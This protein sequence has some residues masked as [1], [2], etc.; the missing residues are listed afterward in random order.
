MNLLQRWR[1]VR[2]GFSPAFWVANFTE[3]FERVGYYSTQAVLAIF[4]TEQL[5]FSAE[6]TG[7]LMGIATFVVYGLPILAGTLADR[8]GF[9]R[10]LMFAYLLLTAGYYMLGSVTA[11]WMAPVRH[12]MGDKWLVLL[13]LLLPAAGPGIVKPCVAGTTARTSTEEARSMGYS[14]YYTLV[15]IGGTIGPLLAWLVRE[16]LGLGMENVFR[17]ASLSVFAMFWVTLFLY[18]EPPS[19]PGTQVTTIYAAIKNMVFVVL[20]NFRFVVFLLITSGFYIVYWQMWVSAPVFLRRYV[21]ANANVDQML[22]IEGFTIIALQIVI[23]FLTRKIPAVQAIAIGFLI[24]GAS[25]TL[26]AV[27]PSVW[28]FPVMLVVLALGEITQASR[29]YEYCSLIAPPG[30]AGL[31]MGYAFLPIAIGALIGEPLGGYLL[32]EFGTVLGRPAAMWW[33]IVA[34]GVLTAAAM[35]IF[36]VVTRTSVA[37]ETPA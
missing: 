14:I 7:W 21:S 9:R 31:Y 37:V 12:A 32:R 27:H 28:I 34:V 22:S 33:V 10:A 17:V 13:I 15:N 3:I 30:Q 5:R 16:R 36:D 6:L 19:E 2:S 1:E 4:L 8:F 24:T 35:W 11:P 23:T 29:Y 20:R 26:L 18:R 25:F